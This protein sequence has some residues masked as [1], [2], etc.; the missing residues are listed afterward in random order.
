[1]I[2]SLLSFSSSTSISSSLS[3]SLAFW[4]LDESSTSTSN[5]SSF[6]SKDSSSSSS[7]SSLPSRSLSS[8]PGGR[9]IRSLRSPG[10][11]FRAMLL[12]FYPNNENILNFIKCE[13]CQTVR[14]NPVDYTIRSRGIFFFLGGRSK[15]TVTLENPNFPN[16]KNGELTLTT[17]LLRVM[18]YRQAQSL[19]HPPP[20]GFHLRGK[21]CLSI[22]FNLHYSNIHV[23]PWG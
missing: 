14:K 6:S 19:H 12:E 11:P 7:S 23:L 2:Q 13:C 15:C 3:W 20:L 9:T 18:S 16:C 22:Q 1:M 5:S 8:E 4:P 10:K 17:L 21:Y